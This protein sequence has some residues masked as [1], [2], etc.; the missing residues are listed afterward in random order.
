MIDLIELLGVS[1]GLCTCTAFIPQIK[2]I[3]T[4]RS[5]KDISLNMY[6][7]YCC[8]LI[9]W[10]TYGFLISS[11]AVVLS[12]MLTLLLSASILVMKLRWDVRT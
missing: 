7:I 2:K 3:F 5:T 11:F 4:T 1:A 9:L 10:T 8:G 6:I 12:N